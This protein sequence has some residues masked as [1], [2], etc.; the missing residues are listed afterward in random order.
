MFTAQT[1]GFPTGTTETRDKDKNSP[2]LDIP[3]RGSNRLY[4][5]HRADLGHSRP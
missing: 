3:D 4:G 5:P 1:A 2:H